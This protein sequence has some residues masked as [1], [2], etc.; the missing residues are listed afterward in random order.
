MRPLP[1]AFTVLLLAAGGLAATSYVY[2]WPAPLAAI[3]PGAGE[4]D[5]ET[6]DAE[7][8]T[9]VVLAEAGLADIALTL[10]AVGDTVAR[11]SVTVT[12]RVSGRVETI[13]FTDGQDVAEGDILVRLD[14][15]DAQDQVRVAEAA[16]EEARQAFGRAARLAEDGTGPRAV[17]N[18]LQRQAEA[19][20]AEVASARERLDDYNIRAPFAGRL[21]LRNISLGALI[22]PGGEVAVLD[23]VDPI[24]IR[25]TVPERYLGE[26]RMGAPMEAAS[27]AFPDERFR[28]EVTAIA[29]RVDPAL[30]TV[31]VEASVPN[32]EEKL[33]PGMLMNVTLETGQREDA[34]TVPPIAVQIEGANHFVF[35]ETEGRAERVEVRVGQRDADRVEIVEGLEAGRRV[36]VE[37][38]Q[39]LASGQAIEPRDRSEGDPPP[40][41]DGPEAGDARTAA[42]A[43]RG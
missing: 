26:I 32:G 21:G 6:E 22:Q 37:G 11:E 20:E 29:T 8:P 43:A 1:T 38:F 40:A 34:V 13:A 39:D 4:R 17:A 30:R 2:G 5:E 16:A 7:P 9:P 15:A 12:A 42:P 25:F 27:V 19:A 10:E 14:P 28:G 23:A 18:D 35:A 36:V 41:R 31:L 24:E 3:L 33:L